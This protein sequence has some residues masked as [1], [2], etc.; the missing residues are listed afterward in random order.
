MQTE[1]QLHCVGPSQLSESVEKY[2]THTKI[3]RPPSNPFAMLT[4]HSINEL[5]TT[6]GTVK[7]VDGIPVCYCF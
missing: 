6:E 7:L 5:D 3:A 1:L 2:K 4:R